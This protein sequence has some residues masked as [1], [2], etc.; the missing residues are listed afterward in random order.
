[1][2]PVLLVI[3]AICSVQF[4]AA[5]A[6]GLFD[7]VG[8]A[9]TVFLRVLF[10]ALALMVVFRPSLRVPS[11]RTLRLL[12]LFGIVLAA[13]NLSFYASLERIPL[14]VAVTLEFV[15]PLWVAVAGSRS[16]VDLI[17]VGLAALGIVLLSDFGSGGLDLLGAALALLAGGF[18][19]AYI[20]LTAQVGRVFEGG[21]GLALA[22]VVAALALTPLGVARGGAELAEPAVLA[23]A[24]GVALLSSAIPYTLEMEALR[25]MPTGVFGVLMSLEPGAA[26]LAGFIVLGEDLS[27]REIVAILLVVAASAGASRG[28]SLAPRDA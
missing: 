8:V 24:L 12:V 13:M 5:I 14:G 10:A 23:V 9:G 27:A 4:G 11:R 18:W 7:E 15:G 28:A 26:A 1:V 20:V 2:P 21:D 3:V 16:A 6:K 25:R 19:A 22:M 17:W